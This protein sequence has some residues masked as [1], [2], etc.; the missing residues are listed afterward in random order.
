MFFVGFIGKYNLFSLLYLILLFWGIVYRY[1][2]NVNLI[3]FI[4]KI[5]YYINGVI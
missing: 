2:D 1:N 3:N 5:N 4:S